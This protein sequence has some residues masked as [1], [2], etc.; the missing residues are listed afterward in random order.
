M[1]AFIL[2]RYRL[3]GWKQIGGFL[4]VHWET[5]RKWYRL[6]GL[7]VVK[8]Q[9]RIRAN[10]NEIERWARLLVAVGRN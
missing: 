1:G 6:N 4:G 10:P 9:G 7:P 2:S 8:F 5:A 3:V